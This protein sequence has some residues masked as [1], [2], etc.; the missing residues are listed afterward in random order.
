LA[1]ADTGSPVGPAEEDDPKTFLIP[2]LISIG[3]TL[4]IGGVV[5]YVVLVVLRRPGIE[6]GTRIAPGSQATAAPGTPG[7]DIIR[8]DG[9]RGGAGSLTVFPTPTPDAYIPERSLDFDIDRLP[10]QRPLFRNI[11][12][13]DSIPPAEEETDTEPQTNPA[14]EVTPQEEEPEGP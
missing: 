3:A 5:M 1:G 8:D 11:P 12:D 9:T 4:L 2:L 13:P 6:P 14:Q 10:T 7:S